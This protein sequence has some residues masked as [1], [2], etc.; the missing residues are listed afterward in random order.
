MRAWTAPLLVLSFFINPIGAP[1]LLTESN[2]LASIII[3]AWAMTVA[4]CFIYVFI[5]W[6]LRAGTRGCEAVL[7]PAQTV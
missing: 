1:L 4:G 2:G 6:Q 5:R 7:N 3:E